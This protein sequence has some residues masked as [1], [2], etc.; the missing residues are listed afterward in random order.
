MRPYEAAVVASDVRAVTGEN[1]VNHIDISVLVAVVVGKIDIGINRITSIDRHRHCSFR[2]IGIVLASVDFH[3][4]DNVE[5]RCENAHRVVA[6]II[7]DRARAGHSRVLVVVVTR[8]ILLFNQVCDD[9]G[10][11]LLIELAVVELDEHDQSAKLRV[12]VN[13][14]AMLLRGLPAEGIFLVFHLDGLLRHLWFQE[15]PRSGEESPFLAL[16][17]R[18]VVC[19]LVARN[20]FA[21]GILLGIDV[22]ALIVAHDGIT[23]FGYVEME[24]L[25]ANEADGEFRAVGLLHLGRSAF[26]GDGLHLR[27]DGNRQ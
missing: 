20:Q 7:D 11:V 26:G 1:E 17:H 9:F 2:T 19:D 25:I 10:V 22:K 14:S 27:T 16:S 21:L 12:V 13:R 3:R 18:L 8:E 15:F 24:E 4:T 23:I 6:E 5:L